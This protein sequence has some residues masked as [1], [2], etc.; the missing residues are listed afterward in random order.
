MAV[1][2]AAR[3]IAGAGVGSVRQQPLQPLEES[4]AG[5]CRYCTPAVLLFANRAG[6][7]AFAMVAARLSD[8][9]HAD[10]SGASVS[11]RI[12]Q[13]HA[14]AGGLSDRVVQAQWGGAG[15]VVTTPCRSELAR[16]ERIDT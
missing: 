7:R 11:G 9:Q 16:E 3:V 10:V 4:R 13:A 15:S 2:P 5:R 12:A 8:P 6:G 1:S 14:G